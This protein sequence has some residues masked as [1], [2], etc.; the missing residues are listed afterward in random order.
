VSAKW[1]TPK[2]K[3]RERERSRASRLGN[4]EWRGPRI[5]VYII[6]YIIRATPD[7]WRRRSS[8]KYWYTKS[9]CHRGGWLG[10][11]CHAVIRFP[12]HFERP[13]HPSRPSERSP[14][15]FPLSS[16]PPPPPPPRRRR[17]PLADVCEREMPTGSRAIRA[18]GRVPF[19]PPS[20]VRPAANSTGRDE[21]SAQRALSPYIWLFLSAR[22][23]EME[24]QIDQL[25]PSCDCRFF[26]NFSRHFETNAR[27]LSQIEATIVKSIRVILY[28]AIFSI[29]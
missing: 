24:K 25:W 4:R 1:N 20:R 21:R 11:C 29:F 9:R 14:V 8:A 3:T 19:A 5:R 6:D 28:I 2:E 18:S 16:S 26:S 10:G 12:S 27:T 7:A 17:Q 22:R 13:L 23:R 15:S